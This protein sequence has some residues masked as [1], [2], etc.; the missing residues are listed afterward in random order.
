MKLI[1]LDEN[2]ISMLN[3]VKH[4]KDYALLTRLFG[5]KISNIGAVCGMVD[6]DGVIHSI[7]LNPLKDDYGL[8]G[9]YRLRIL[10]TQTGDRTSFDGSI[11]S[12]RTILGMDTIYTSPI[13]E[14]KL[15]ISLSNLYTNIRVFKKNIVCI[16]I[17]DSDIELWVDFDMVDRNLQIPVCVEG[18][19]MLLSF[20]D[21][22]YDDI[23]LA[24]STMNNLVTD[25]IKEY[26]DGEHDLY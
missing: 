4:H 21:N 8:T 17:I 5:L 22:E 12:I 9:E 11:N 7:S 24:C 6:D 26:E 19:E 14:D 3:E 20:R 13:I 25:L 1:K 18:S 23:T 10:N 15:H 16:S 2:S